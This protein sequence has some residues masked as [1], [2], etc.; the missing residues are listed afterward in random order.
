M[1]HTCYKDD[2]PQKTEEATVTLRKRDGT[3][4]FHRKVTIHTGVP[5]GDWVQWS[6]RRIGLR[7]TGRHEFSGEVRNVP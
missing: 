1:T 5:I 7:R 3:E 2:Q 4:L 6:G